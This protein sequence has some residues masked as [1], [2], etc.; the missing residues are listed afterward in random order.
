MA[1]GWGFGF[2]YSLEKCGI[3]WAAMTGL[4]YK[5]LNRTLDFTCAYVYVY[6]CGCPGWMY[7]CVFNC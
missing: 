5:G 4:G 1:P 2:K 3:G 6:V 7:M